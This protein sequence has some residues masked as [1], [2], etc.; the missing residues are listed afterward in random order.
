MDVVR[1][2]DMNKT[3]DVRTRAIIN[4]WCA[5]VDITFI[6]PTLSQHSIVSL[7]QNAGMICGIGDNRQ[8]KGKGNFGSW[9]VDFEGNDQF[10]DVWETRTK[11][12][13]K[14]QEKAMKDIIINDAETQ[15]LYDF[16]KE[17]VIKRAA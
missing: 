15:E 1:S 2:S 16:Y 11:I 8:E 6:T 9:L 12:G 17:E 14:A 5:E 7:L 3:P 4:E 13:R 10:K